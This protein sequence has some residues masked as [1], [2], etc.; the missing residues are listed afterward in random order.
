MVF[1]DPAFVDFLAARLARLHVEFRA[2]AES[3]NS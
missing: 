2:V 1:E 3:R